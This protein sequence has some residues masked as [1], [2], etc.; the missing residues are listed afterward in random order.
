MTEWQ[1]SQSGPVGFEVGRGPLAAVW[2]LE[3]HKLGETTF[4]HFADGTAHKNRM[5]GN[6]FVK[7]LMYA[8]AVTCSSCHDVHGTEQDA[9]L[10]KPA[11]RI[12]LDCHGPNTPN[13]PRA[14]TIEEHTHH[15]ADS[16]GS[17]CIECH[18]PQIAQTIGD[19]NVRSHTFHFVTPAK[20]SVDGVPNA[21]NVCHKDQSVA[22]ASTALKSWTNRSPW[23]MGE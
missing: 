3:E 5:Q 6:D 13:G 18:M 8:R 2:K 15:K 7:S 22:W 21:C 23:R 4:T 14:A 10:W 17:R 9:V 1:P 19:T 16:A 20:T 11:D 12:C